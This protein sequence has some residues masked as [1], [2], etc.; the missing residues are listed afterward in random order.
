MSKRTT[1]RMSLSDPGMV[2]AVKD[3]IEMEKQMNV[4]AAD[5]ERAVV[6]AQ[7][8]IENDKL[9]LVG[10]VIEPPYS[11]RIMDVL[12]ERKRAGV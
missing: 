3:A 7:V 9:V 2:A 4:G 8:R 1:F 11:K 5:N 10:G 6:F 12:T